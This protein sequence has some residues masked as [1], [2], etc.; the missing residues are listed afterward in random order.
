MTIKEFYAELNRFSPRFKVNPYGEIRVK[1]VRKKAAGTAYQVERGPVCPICYVANRKLKKH[2]F[3]LAA[4]PA[5]M[6]LGLSEKATQ[7]IM[8]AADNM[9]LTPRIMATRRKLLKFVE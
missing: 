6:Y 8:D 4:T 3:G 7:H 1:N 9:Y 5:G 2:K